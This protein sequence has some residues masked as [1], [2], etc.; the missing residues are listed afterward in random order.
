MLPAR[1]CAFL[2][3]CPACVRCLCMCVRAC[4]RAHCPYKRLPAQQVQCSY[5]R[6]MSTHR[7]TQGCS[8]AG[9]S[10]LALQRRAETTS[11]S[12]PYRHRRRY[13]HRAGTDVPVLRMTAPARAFQRYKARAHTQSLRGQVHV[14]KDIP[15]RARLRLVCSEGQ[16]REYRR[17]TI[18]R[19]QASNRRAYRHALGTCHAHSRKAFAEA[20]ARRYLCGMHAVGDADVE[21]RL[22]RAGARLVCSEGQKREYRRATID[23]PQARCSV[24]GLD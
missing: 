1:I 8:R 21:S 7:C 12:T 6:R 15:E 13:V 10:A 2:S 16:K 17:T 9:S 18:D 14:L 23:R 22:G 24:L 3:T 5:M 20:P 11:I 4:A 19:P